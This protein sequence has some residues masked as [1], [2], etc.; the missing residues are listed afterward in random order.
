MKLPMS[1]L[2]KD[3]QEWTEKEL[4]DFYNEVLNCEW[5]RDPDLLDLIRDFAV[6]MHKMEVRLEIAEKEI[7]YTEY[8]R[9]EDRERAYYDGH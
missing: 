3:A 2:L 9:K 8:D 1:Y 7:E 5:T 6:Y 4:L